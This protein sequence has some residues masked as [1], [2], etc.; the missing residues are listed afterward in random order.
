M[1]FINQLIEFNQSI[2]SKRAF[3]GVA[4]FFAN[5]ILPPSYY[6][7]FLCMVKINLKDDSGRMICAV[8]GIKPGRVGTPTSVA[9]TACSSLPLTFG[10][11][12]APS[13]VPLLLWFPFSSLSFFLLLIFLFF[14]PFVHG[15]VGLCLRFSK[16]ST[17]HGYGDFHPRT[18]WQDDSNTVQETCL[19]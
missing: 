13:V 18:T 15:A 17:R 14:C 12:T 9:P 5:L 16:T 3:N 7:Y 10:C 6:Y 1:W 19:L 11:A 8:S 4:P 2:V